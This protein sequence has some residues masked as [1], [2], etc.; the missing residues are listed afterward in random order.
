MNPRDTPRKTFSAPQ[1]YW[2]V[3]DHIVID[4]LA[5]NPSAALR[6]VI[7]EYLRSRQQRALA[8]AAGQLD[9]D[10]W[11]NLSGLEND[12]ETPPPPWSQLAVDDQD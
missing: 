1:H 3:L 4:G 6:H 10:D 12:T 2:D 9:E 5:K 7:D 11:L 8:D